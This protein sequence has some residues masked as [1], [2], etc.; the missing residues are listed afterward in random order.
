MI[1][2]WNGKKLTGL[3]FAFAV[4][5][6][7]RDVDPVKLQELNHALSLGV[8]NMDAVLKENKTLATKIELSEYFNTYIDFHFDSEKEKALELFFELNRV[9]SL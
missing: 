7:R 9:F 8:N 6:A 3:P 2:V 5:I 4:W 1:L